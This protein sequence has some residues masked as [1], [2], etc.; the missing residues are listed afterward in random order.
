MS[1]LFPHLYARFEA[2]IASLDC[3][4]RC[5]PYNE[6][7]VPFCCDTRHTIPTAYL[8]EWEFL[9]SST[10]LWHAYRAPD[11]AEAARLAA[12]TPAG[13][14]LIECL[15]HDRCQRSFRSVVC[16]AFPFFPYIT[17]EGKF[18][19][20]AYYW[21]YEDRCWVISHLEVVTPE[22][23]GQFVGAFEA[24][25]AAYPEELEGFR[26]ESIRM[27]RVF[28]RRKRAIP[29]LHRNGRWYKIS[30]RSGRLRRVDAQALGLYGVYK[31]VESL[32]FSEA[33]Y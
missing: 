3:G 5:A 10:D 31:I 25:F 20:L 16:R 11:A 15:G 9:Q 2:P 8:A 24:L 18:I 29:L 17:R 30:P 13:Q 21:E 7:G 6:R 12:Q 28:G 14:V 33:L 23:R 4:Q 1:L 32:P 19:G 27:R 26:Q 22:Y